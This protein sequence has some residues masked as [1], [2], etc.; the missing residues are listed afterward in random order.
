MVITGD[1]T[2]LGQPE[3]YATLRGILANVV[4]PWFVVPGNHDDRRHLLDTFAD[5]EVLA[6]CD[7]FVHYCVDDL[8]V[9]LIGLDTTLPGECYG[10]LCPDRLSWLENQLREG[11]ARPTVVF[12]HHPPFEPGI[13]HMDAQNLRNGE[14]EL[15]LLSK[16]PQVRRVACGHVHRPSETCIRGIGAS[17]APSAAPSVTLDLH[18]EALPTFTMDPPAIRLFRIAAAGVVTSH[19]SYVGQIEGLHPFFADDGA[20]R[21]WALFPQAEDFGARHPARPDPRRQHQ[22]RSPAG[23]SALA[24]GPIASPLACGGRINTRTQMAISLSLGDFL[25]PEM[26]SSRRFFRLYRSSAP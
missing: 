26:V 9:R 25:Q 17:V 18:P 6:G 20:L 13:R 19:L 15:A 8:P 7:G 2:D 1:L 12:Q 10:W 5:R 11:R 14:E 21:D 24:V 3:E 22:D 16:F 23:S 4:A